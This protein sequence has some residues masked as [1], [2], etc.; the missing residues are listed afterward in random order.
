MP[1]LRVSKVARLDLK[2]IARYTV[3]QWGDAQ[4]EK[5]LRQLGARFRLLAKSPAQGRPADEIRPG[6]MKFRE[7]RHLIFYRANAKTVD[8][9]RVLHEM[10]D[11]AS[12]FD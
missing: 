11:P 6:L 8:I 12:H 4:A 9:I 5:Y 10:M 2:D 3:K 7:G 1:K